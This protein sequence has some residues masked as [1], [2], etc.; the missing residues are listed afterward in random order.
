M[1]KL[2][3][4]IFMVIIQG[5]TQVPVRGLV[6]PPLREQTNLQ[7]LG[8]RRLLE[9]VWHPMNLCNTFGTTRNS[10]ASW[11]WDRTKQRVKEQ[12]D[13]DTQNKMFQLRWK[14]LAYLDPDRY[15]YTDFCFKKVVIHYGG[16]SSKNY[17]DC[18]PTA[19]VKSAYDTAA[20][21][22]L[23]TCSGF[24][25]I[26]IFPYGN[27]DLGPVRFP[28][29]RD[30]YQVSPDPDVVFISLIEQNRT[31]KGVVFDAGH[32]NQK[33]LLDLSGI[34]YCYEFL[35][36]HY[37]PM[38]RLALAIIAAILLLVIIFILVCVVK[39]KKKSANAPD[40]EHHSASTE[41]TGVGAHGGTGE[42]AH[43]GTGEGTHG[44]TPSRASWS[45]LETPSEGTCSMPATFRTRHRIR[46]PMRTASGR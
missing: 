2:C 5:L 45:A 44:F 43:R 1:I 31:M 30:Y 13:F 34:P 26:T 39:K 25:K 23:C 14:N 28:L 11:D 8:V 22:P 35:A 19:F 38:T 10:Y 33:L 3:L 18:C 17:T 7:H 27:L 32:F 40:P 24:N 16:S 4:F 37:N 12:S 21:R 46:S 20:L 15:Y 9:S 36:W 42:E 41:G 6:N 29:C